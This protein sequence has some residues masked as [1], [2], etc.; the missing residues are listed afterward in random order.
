MLLRQRIHTKQKTSRLRR[1]LRDPCSIK[2]IDDQ[3][4][5]ELFRYV[6][7]YLKRLPLPFGSRILRLTYHS[8]RF[9]SGVTLKSS[10]M[11]VAGMSP[12]LI[13]R[14]WISAAAGTPKVLRRVWAEI[15]YQPDRYVRWK[16]GTSKCV[17]YYP[18]AYVSI[19][20]V[21]PSFKAFWQKIWMHFS[22]LS[23]TPLF[24]STSINKM[25]SERKLYSVI[26][27]FITRKKKV[28]KGL[29]N[30]VPLGTVSLLSY[31]CTK[32]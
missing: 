31:S 26:A 4:F 5:P 12:T 25:Q 16:W 19:Y 7:R 18:I 11:G 13:L 20:K 30:N 28:D 23:C 9:L 32:K 27:F 21:V 10:C 17:L 14:Y 29:Q 24:I 2:K 1:F 8:T 15:S 3:L 6:A 22:F